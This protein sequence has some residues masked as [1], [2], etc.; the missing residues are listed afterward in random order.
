MNKTRPNKESKNTND[1]SISSFF[2]KS[3]GSVLESNSEFDKRKRSIVKVLILNRKKSDAKRCDESNSDVRSKEQTKLEG[4]KIEG[5]KIP[6]ESNA[7]LQCS[8]TMPP[9]WFIEYMEAVS[10]MY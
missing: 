3:D 4:I 6:K 7:L 9:P 8:D 5:I 1:D 2:E 10:D